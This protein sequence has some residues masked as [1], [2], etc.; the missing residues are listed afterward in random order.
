MPFFSP[1][2]LRYYRNKRSERREKKVKNRNQNKKQVLSIRTNKTIQYRLWIRMDRLAD[3]RRTKCSCD[4]TVA[5]A[6]TATNAFHS[7][8]KKGSEGNTLCEYAP[9]TFRMLCV[10]VYTLIPPYY[11]FHG[12]HQS[13]SFV[14]ADSPVV[15]CG[16]HATHTEFR[17]DLCRE[18]IW[19]YS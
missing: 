1:I 8:E 4:A 13:S 2:L 17:A 14:S 11:D 6:T 15:Y 5:H 19:F 7:D 18:N 16:A 3:S 10:R 9:H 12:G